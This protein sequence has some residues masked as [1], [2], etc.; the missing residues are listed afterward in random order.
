MSKFTHVASF[1]IGAVIG[2]VVTGVVL[3]K[4][5]EEI[6][7]VEIDSVKEA[8]AK[9]AAAEADEEEEERPDLSDEEKEAVLEQYGEMANKYTSTPKDVKD[10]TNYVCVISPEEFGEISNFHIVNLTL[11]ND[12]VLADEEGTIVDVDKT[13]GS[14]ALTQIGDYEENVVHVRNM[15][16]KTDFEI[17]CDDNNYSEVYPNQAE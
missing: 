9:K 3:K 14:Y 7:Q 10:V 1:A 4:K 8:Y 6:I 5:Y 13:V 12:G 11:Y 16:L 2:S 17:L 15:K